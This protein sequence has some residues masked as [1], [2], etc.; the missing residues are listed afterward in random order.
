MLKTSTVPSVPAIIRGVI[1]DYG[2]VICLRPAETKIQRLANEFSLDPAEFLVRYHKNRSGYDQGVTSAEDYWQDVAGA[3]TQIS[4]SHLTQLRKWDVELWS[5]LDPVMLAWIE[6][7]QR[8]GFK[9]ALLSNMHADMATHVRQAF[10]W[11]AR[12][13]VPIL[14]CE[15]KIVKPSPE[16]YTRSLEKLGLAPQEALFIDDR[17]V[18]V[19]AAQK[20]G[21]KTVHFASVEQLRKDLIEMQFP[22]L[23]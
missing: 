14:S 16:I 10:K 21:L 13:D 23:P 22:V 9:T 18:N 5:E 7:L 11:V 17:I 6:N 19:E 1:L 8:G 2:E 20:V 4:A 12:L 3:G 15:L